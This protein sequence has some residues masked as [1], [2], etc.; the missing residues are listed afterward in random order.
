MISWAYFLD[1]VSKCLAVSI[2][3]TRNAPK[4]A[5]IDFLVAR[6]SGTALGIGNGAATLATL[7]ILCAV[8][9]LWKTT[10]NKGGAWTVGHGLLTGGALGN[11]TDR[12]LRFPGFP[13]GHVVDFIYI[14]NVAI[15]NLADVF[16]YAGATVLVTLF[17]KSTQTDCC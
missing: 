8:A 13:R 12:L 6:N 17:L 4:T 3:E 10:K 5:N 7:F 16:I 2:L 14:E 9:V 15:F 1:L 11:L